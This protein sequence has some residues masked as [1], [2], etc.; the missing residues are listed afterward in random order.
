MFKVWRSLNSSVL[1]VMFGQCNDAIFVVWGRFT[2]SDGVAHLLG[3]VGTRQGAIE[4]KQ[5]TSSRCLLLLRPCTTH[6][7]SPICTE[8]TLYC[9]LSSLGDVLALQFV[10]LCFMC[11]LRQ[12][13]CT[14]H[15]ATFYKPKK[16]T[17]LWNTLVCLMRHSFSAV[18]CYVTV[19][20][21]SLL[22]WLH[23]LV[24][25][26]CPFSLCRRVASP[27]LSCRGTHE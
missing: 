16:S 2:S 18:E 1:I 20:D 15:F 6:G 24:Y 7:N 12:A 4:G 8:H 10:L 27:E 21:S 9:S 19:F 26:N 25:C 11:I 3:V 22:D 17:L 23:G 13:I 5:S 14:C